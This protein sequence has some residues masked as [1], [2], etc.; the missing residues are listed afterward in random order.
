MK[1]KFN[2]LIGDT[3]YQAEIEAE[4]ERAFFDGAQFY[5]SLPRVCGNKKC[6]KKCLVPKHSTPKGY[7]YYYVQCLACG[8]KAQFGQT[9]EGNKLFFKGWEPPQEKQH[10]SPPPAEEDIPF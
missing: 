3:A 10:Q 4:D 7:D 9:K 8:Y 2:F 5:T 1:F 6:G